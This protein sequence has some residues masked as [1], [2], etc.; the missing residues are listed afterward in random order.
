[1]AFLDL[2]PNTSWSSVIAS[3]PDQDVANGTL[4]FH[5]ADVLVRLM[6][7]DSGLDPTSPASYLAVSLVVIALSVVALVILASSMRI[8]A[9][10]WVPGLLAVAFTASL[11]LWIG[12]EGVAWRDMPVAA[13]LTV[14]TAG[15]VILLSRTGLRG[16]AIASTVLI[17]IGTVVAV[18]T[19]AGTIA[20]VAALIVVSLLATL[21]QQRKTREVV[22]LWVFCL[23]GFAGGVALSAALHPVGRLNPIEWI[24]VSVTLA[25][26]NPNA[27]LVKVLAQDI[28]SSDLPWWYIPVYV[29]AQV[30][31]LTLVLGVGAIVIIVLGSR[32]VPS[33]SA[34]LRQQAS[35][36][37]LV[38]QAVVLPVGIILIGAN[39]YD[40]LRHVLFIF[41]AAFGL[42]GLIYWTF[43]T[44][45]ATR[46][47]RISVTCVIGM[48]LGLS[49]FASARWF[50]Y[51]YAFVNPVAGAIKDPRIWELDY[52][53]LSVREGADRLRNGGS[54]LIGALPSANSA[55]PWG[56]GE[57]VDGADSVYVFL[58]WDAALPT[59]C[60][61]T[62]RIERDGHVLGVGGRC[63][64]ENSARQ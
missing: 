36:W 26:D 33:L 31:L 49:L 4:R 41:P 28:I 1:M 47:V 19:R 57:G 48:A 63:A 29:L 43:L 13:G 24:R 62:F 44:R 50:P 14:A 30:P 16:P 55:A 53:G 58:R 34:A 25:S 7:Q 3:V 20:L 40:G 8:V 54:S 52:W 6:G 11:P 12:L 39:L 42:L 46:R 5:L 2:Q 64:P 35:W 59:S 45:W 61:E 10:S 27:T 21:V 38:V 18:S 15:L 37:P 32:R 22:A 56:V 51:S 17:G 23:G 60:S 9:G